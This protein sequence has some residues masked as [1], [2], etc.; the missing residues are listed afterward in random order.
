MTTPETLPPFEEAE[1]LALEK[2]VA[3]ARGSGPDI[4]HE[5]VRAEL[6][7]W[8]E[9]ARRRIAALDPASRRAPAAE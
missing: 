1:R 2:A 3:E 9:E 8:I 6:Q 7:H 5:A 4:P